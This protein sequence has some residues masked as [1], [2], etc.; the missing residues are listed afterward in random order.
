[1]AGWMLDR[2]RLTSV[3]LHSVGCECAGVYGRWQGIGMVSR[4][5]IPVAV[6]LIPLSLGLGSDGEVRGEKME[7][8]KRAEPFR[9][10]HHG[11][12]DS[13]AFCLLLC[14]REEL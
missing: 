10:R 2:T 4:S 8:F 13:F 1:M 11:C 3:L 7:I 6:P 5:P 9:G 14:L 12:F